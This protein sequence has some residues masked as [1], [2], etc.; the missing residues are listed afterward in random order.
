MKDREKAITQEF[1]R[2]NLSYDPETGIFTWLSSRSNVRAGA[3]AGRVNQWGHRTIRLLGKYYLAHRLAWFLIYG[4]WPIEDIDHINMVPDD[5]RISNL[6]EAT[7]SQN[8]YNR[9]V[10]ADSRT[11]VKGV[12]LIPKTGRY[13]VRIR[14]EGKK[15]RI[16]NFK[17]LEEAQAAYAAAS[18]R[19]HGEYGRTH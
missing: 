2:A 19:H 16:G 5:N 10:R 17:T 4:K 9:K 12:C 11:G 1:L 3:K 6:R 8:H 18:Q 15:I 14:A 13:E 7:K